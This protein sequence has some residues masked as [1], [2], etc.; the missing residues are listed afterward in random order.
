MLFFN[1]YP[2]PELISFVGYPFDESPNQI[3]TGFYSASPDDDFFRYVAS[4]YSQNHQKM[5]NGRNCG[6]K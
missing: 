6:D 3:K 4:I 1:V 5:K 2:A